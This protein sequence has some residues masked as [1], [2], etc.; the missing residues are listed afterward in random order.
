MNKTM[1]AIITPI[2]S[3]IGLIIQLFFGIDLSD[4]QLTIISDGFVAFALALA[5]IV[6][7]F[8]AYKEKKENK[9]EK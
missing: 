8:K 4:E 2:V 7:A 5:T 6:G 1:Q 3:F 9:E